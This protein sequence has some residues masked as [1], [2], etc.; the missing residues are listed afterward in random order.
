MTKMVN[1]LNGKWNQ[2][3]FWFHDASVRTEIRW[4][5]VLSIW[6]CDKFIWYLS[7]DWQLVNGIPFKQYKLLHELEVARHQTSYYANYAYELQC[8]ILEER[9]SLRPRNSK[10]KG[11]NPPVEAN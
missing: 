8:Q 9:K 7:E 11:N 4:L 2:A 1:Y 3:I 10:K 6:A 5:V